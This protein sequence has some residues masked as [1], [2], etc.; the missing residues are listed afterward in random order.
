M[1][2]RMAPDF[3]ESRCRR[4]WFVKT[5]KDFIFGLVEFEVA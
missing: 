5:S 3:G 4:N 2:L 1:E